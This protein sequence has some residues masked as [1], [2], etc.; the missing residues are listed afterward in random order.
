MQFPL[1]ISPIQWH[2]LKE[3]KKLTQYPSLLLSI[4]S[5][6]SFCLLLVASHCFQMVVFYVFKFS[7]V[8]GHSIGQIRVT[9][10]LAEANSLCLLLIW[11]IWDLEWSLLCWVKKQGSSPDSSVLK[12]IKCLFYVPRP[13]ITLF[14]INTQTMVY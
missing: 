7:I 8:A 12:F 5:P 3:N 1:W 6:S 4:F 10:P 9:P 11:V 14:H 2:Q 13:Y